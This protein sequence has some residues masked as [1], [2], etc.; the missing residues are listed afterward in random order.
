MIDLLSM[1][2]IAFGTVTPAE[3]E[4]C[5]ERR[6]QGSGP[7]GSGNDGQVYAA[8]PAC[9]GLKEKNGEFIASAVGHRMGCKM[10]AALGKAV[11]LSLVGEDQGTDDFYE[12]EEEEL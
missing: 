8:C 10:A 7:M 3:L 9:G 6:G 2:Q 4:W 12:E 1:Y 11:P 5:G